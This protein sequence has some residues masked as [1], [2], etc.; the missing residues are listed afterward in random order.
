MEHAQIIIV[1]HA[2]FFSDL[3]LRSQGVSVFPDHDVVILDEAYTVESVAG[4]HLGPSVSSGQGRI[5]FEK[6]VQ[7]PDE[8]RAV[9][10]WTV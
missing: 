1:N 9:S 4:D 8:Q 10:R 5:Y 2:M 7:R 6:V 3:A